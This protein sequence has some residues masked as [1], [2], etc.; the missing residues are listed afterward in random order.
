MTDTFKKLKE[1]MSVYYPDFTDDELETNINKLIEFFTLAAK[2][3]FEAEK[4]QDTSF[5]EGKE[6]KVLKNQ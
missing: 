3:V 5:P 2:A 4:I 6:V 1:E